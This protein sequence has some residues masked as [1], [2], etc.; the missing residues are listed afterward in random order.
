M[1]FWVTTMEVLKEA[2]VT[3]IFGEHDG[4]KLEE[5]VSLKKGFYKVKVDANDG[6]VAFI[7]IVK[8]KKPEKTAESKVKLPMVS[9][10]KQEK[11]EEQT[12]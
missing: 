2:T 7:K 11:K 6:T 8:G 9:A 3:K 4:L 5:P 1:V 12:D 10:K